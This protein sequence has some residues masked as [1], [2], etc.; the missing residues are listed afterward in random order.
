MIYIA[1]PYPYHID[2]QILDEQLHIVKRGIL[3]RC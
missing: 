1:T 2:A 3:P